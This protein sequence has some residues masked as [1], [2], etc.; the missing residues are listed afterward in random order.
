MRF[1]QTLPKMT[2]VEVVILSNVQFKT[3]YIFTKEFFV[4]NR[5]V[6]V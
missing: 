2:N 6:W 3:C 5:E 4:A 1:F